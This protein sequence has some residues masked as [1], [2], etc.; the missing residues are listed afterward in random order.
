VTRPATARQ[1]LAVQ[2]GGQRRDQLRAI[3]FSF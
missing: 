3:G 1:P 2:L